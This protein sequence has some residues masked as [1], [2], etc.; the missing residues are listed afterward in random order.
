MEAVSIGYAQIYSLAWCLDICKRI[1][2]ALSAFLI[3]DIPCLSRCSIFNFFKARNNED[4]LFS[5]SMLSKQKL[6]AAHKEHELMY[7]K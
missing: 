6:D 2:L 5:Q 1:S 3:S 7:V 4:K